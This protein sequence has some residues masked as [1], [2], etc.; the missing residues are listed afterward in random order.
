[1]GRFI[2]P[3]KVVEGQTIK[4]KE[5]VINNNPFN[6]LIDEGTPTTVP[7]WHVNRELSSWDENTL[8]FDKLIG[9][10][11]PIVY[12]R[13][14]N[15]VVYG[16]DKLSTK[17]SK[18][19]TVNLKINGLTMDLVVVPDT[20]KPSINDLVNFEYLDTTYFFK[21]TQIEMDT[22][23][24]NPFYRITISFSKIIDEDKLK[25]ISFGE[26]YKLVYENIGTSSKTVIRK[27]DYLDGQ[28][29]QEILDELIG[30]Y[31]F[32]FY[33]KFVLN[34]TCKYPVGLDGGDNDLPDDNLE[35]EFA[36]LKIDNNSYMS[37]Y[38]FDIYSMVTNSV[39]NKIIFDDSFIENIKNNISDT[40]N[41]IDDII[42][43]LFNNVDIDFEVMSS[44][45]IRHEYEH[46]IK[47]PLIMAGIKKE[48]DRKYE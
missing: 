19:D 20:F 8:D 36:L 40:G 33:D 11:S 3:S 22:I 24:N 26:S 10:D 39:K 1:M 6:Q 41:I 28:K 18:T 47:L 12:D 7:Y 17:I 31:D 27:S 2:N 15:A 34:Y 46:F 29:L 32:V 21:V 4:Y 25:E 5:D 43:K 44:F 30:E 16:V 35:N 13:I 38:R 23:R 42:V 9:E 48:L 14:E 45:K 37:G